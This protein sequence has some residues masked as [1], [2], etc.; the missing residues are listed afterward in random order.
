MIHAVRAVDS[1]VAPTLS[2]P[3][4]F[5]SL[6]Q[7]RTSHIVVWCLPLDL[8]QFISPQTSTSCSH[9]ARQRRK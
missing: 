7:M 8:D 2:R 5:N 6:S 9:V 4:F 1:F 3:A